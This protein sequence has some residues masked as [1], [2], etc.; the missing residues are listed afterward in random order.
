MVLLDLG[1]RNSLEIRIECNFS[2]PQ[3]HLSI[4]KLGAA[5]KIL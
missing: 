3:S 4:K 1:V 2:M 5:V